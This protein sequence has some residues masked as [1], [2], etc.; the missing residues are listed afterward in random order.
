MP[1]LGKGWLFYEG[2]GGGSETPVL[3]EGAKGPDWVTDFLFK[4]H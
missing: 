2:G 1:L 4:N 3:L